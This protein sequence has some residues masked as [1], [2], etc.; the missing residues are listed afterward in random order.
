VIVVCIIKSDYDQLTHAKTTIYFIQSY[1]NVF[2]A[3]GKNNPQVHISKLRSYSQS[4]DFANT[5]LSPQQ[6]FC[7]LFVNKSHLMI[8]NIKVVALGL[9]N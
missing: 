4:S 2:M 9:Y 5:L 6:K 7:G 1:L 8:Q 3:E